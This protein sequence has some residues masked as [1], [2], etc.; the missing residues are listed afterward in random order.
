MNTARKSKQTT[1]TDHISTVSNILQ[2]QY[3]YLT[4][5][6]F[7]SNI[8]SNS[9]IIKIPKT[10]KYFFFLDWLFSRLAGTFTLDE[11][12]CSLKMEAAHLFLFLLSGLRN[13]SSTYV[14]SS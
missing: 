6:P 4:N 1:F 3:N 12:S 10:K 5:F 11:L 13:S 2:K 9:T 14:C 8:E 7:L